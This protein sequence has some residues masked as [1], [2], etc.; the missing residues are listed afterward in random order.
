MWRKG[1]SN[2]ERKKL[3][4]FTFITNI[5]F[6]ITY[7]M[8][9]FLIGMEF[10]LLRI[11]SSHWVCV[12]LPVSVLF[13]CSVV[14]FGSVFICFQN[15]TYSI[16]SSNS[17]PLTPW[18]F[19][20]I[21]NEFVRESLFTRLVSLD[22]FKPYSVFLVPLT[23]YSIPKWCYILMF[24]HSWPWPILLCFVPIFILALLAAHLFIYM[25]FYDQG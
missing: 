10:T 9:F 8:F 13:P 21:W 20:P 3:V 17:V 18:Y 16:W 2:R 7:M 15:S 14:F 5:I 1:R 23:K 4:L 6:K 25:A 11:N 22:C 19:V 12:P 24:G